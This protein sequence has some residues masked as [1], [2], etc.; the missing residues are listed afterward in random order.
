MEERIFDLCFWFGSLFDCCMMGIYRMAFECTTTDGW[1]EWKGWD[2]IRLNGW[3]PWWVLI[4]IRLMEIPAITSWYG[5]YFVVFFTGFYTSQIVEDFFHQ[6]YQHI[7]LMDNGSIWRPGNWLLDMCSG[8]PINPSYWNFN[9]LL[10]LFHMFQPWFPYLTQWAPINSYKGIAKM[11]VQPGMLLGVGYWI[12]WLTERLIDRL[13]DACL[14][15]AS[16]DPP[17]TNPSESR[18]KPKSLLQKTTEA[19]GD[20]IVLSK[21]LE[22]L[23]IP[24]MPVSENTAGRRNTGQKEDENFLLERLLCWFLGV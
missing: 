10:F 21:L 20:K 3:I 14:L 2:W 11:S 13:I 23:G 15:S 6:Q 19:L 5:K 1:T 24:Q 7:M 9:M 22:N 12:D 16:L 8:I 17:K 18:Q 4:L